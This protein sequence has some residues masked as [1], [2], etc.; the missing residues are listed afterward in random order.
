MSYDNWKCSAP[1]PVCGT[2]CCE[3]SEPERD[4]EPCDECGG[5][6]FIEVNHAGQAD[7]DHHD[8]PNGCVPA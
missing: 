1:C 7:A 4:E 5:L 6:G 8:C 3:C 2:P